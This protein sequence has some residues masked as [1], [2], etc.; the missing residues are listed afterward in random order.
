MSGLS[1]LLK[2]R[3]QKKT[4]IEQ[5]SSSSSSPVTLSNS[6]QS[7]QDI[8]YF[9]LAYIRNNSHRQCSA[10][11]NLFVENKSFLGMVNKHSSEYPVLR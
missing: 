7:T 2:Y 4:N 8:G 11:E 3:Y 1:S 6:N 5:S 9:Q 10:H